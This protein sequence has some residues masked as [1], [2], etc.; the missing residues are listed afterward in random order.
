MPP[1]KIKKGEKIALELG[2]FLPGALMRSVINEFLFN[3]LFSP[4]CVAPRGCRAA[5]GSAPLV[6]SFFFSVPSLLYKHRGLV[7]CHLLIFHPTSDTFASAISS[8]LKRIINLS[9][10]VF[11]HFL[12]AFTTLENGSASAAETS[13]AHIVVL[14]LKS[15]LRE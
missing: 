12:F 3:A 8:T 13:T 9:R 11:F 5:S 15:R 10:I 2:N 7:M 14:V 1:F 6:L 4:K